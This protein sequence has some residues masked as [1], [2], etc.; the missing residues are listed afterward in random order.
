MDKNILHKQSH[1]WI[2][3]ILIEYWNLNS[4]L[5]FIKNKI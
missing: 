4:M 5:F 3:I 2:V 1:F